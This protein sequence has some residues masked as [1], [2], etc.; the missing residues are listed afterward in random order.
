MVTPTNFAALLRRLAAAR[1]LVAGALL[2]AG[3][4]LAQSR[5]VPFDLAPFALCLLGAAA[6]SG[7]YLVWQP[8]GD[9][10]LWAWLQ[11]ILDVVLVS[12]IVAVTGGP[13]SLFTFLYVLSISA[14]SVILSRPGGLAIAGLASLLY[15]G[16]VLGRTV[17]PLSLLAEPSSATA[18]EVLTMFMNTGVFLVV[19]IVTGTMAEQYQRLHREL[20]VQQDHL[21]D[22]QAF[23]D[24]IFESLGSGLIAL[25]PAGRITAFNRAAEEITG[26]AAFEVIGRQWQVVFGDGMALEEVW[27]SVG[28]PDYQAVRQ[29]L[30][31]RRKDGAEVPLGI[32][33][34]PLRSGQGSL[35]GLIGLCQDLSQIKQMEQRVRQADRLATVGRL[36]ANIAHEIRNPLASLAGA[37]E[38]LSKE[39]PP[40]DETGVRLTD[41]AL[42]ESARLDRII[43]DFLEYARPTPL[44]LVQVNLAEILDEV[45]LL[46]EHGPL[47][48][49]VKIVRDYG[50]ELSV[51][52]DAQQLRQAIWNLCPNALDA[53]PEGGE[54]RIGAR[55]VGHERAQ[56]LEVWV[57]DT[58]RGIKAEDLAHVFEPFYSTKAEGSGLG[59]AVVDRVVQEHGGQVEVWS[60]PGEGTTFTLRLPQMASQRRDVIRLGASRGRP[61]DHRSARQAR[62]GVPGDE[63]AGGER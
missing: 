17:F 47:P 2:V 18:L 63:R 25:D 33:F 20:A 1:L 23:K 58:G 28:D 29:E 53:M 54:L 55:I 52:V 16:L 13:Q 45:V 43:R 7:V 26:F 41:I 9:L 62:L 24:L 34:W 10:R 60:A 37:I 3:G 5:A 6:A 44:Q 38:A 40:G 15:S 4:L 42:R 19:A 35:M 49:N 51:R 11:L 27:A 39:L 12:A 46:L 8:T 31:L 56:D 57:A 48:P 32:A 30:Q 36:A 59:L 61:D 50:Q 22:L 21:D 14:A